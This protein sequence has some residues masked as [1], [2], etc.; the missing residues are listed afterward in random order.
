[1]QSYLTRESCHG[2]PLSQP[3]RA[4]SMP[5]KQSYAAAGDDALCPPVVD[6]SGIHGVRFPFASIRMGTSGT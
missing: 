4:L 5:A 6:D 3:L 2:G 1:M